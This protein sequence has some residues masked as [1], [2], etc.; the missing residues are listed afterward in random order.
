M[1]ITQIIQGV[2]NPSAGPT[3]CVG[4]LSEE[5]RKLGDDASILTLGDRPHEWPYHAPLHVHTGRLEHGTGVSLAM[6]E[7]IR[8]LARA[9][10]ILHGNSIWRVTNL[11]PL[12]VGDKAPARIVCSPHGTLS[13]WSMRRRSALKTPFWKLLQKPA[14]ERC[15]CYHVTAAHEYAD[16]RRMGLRRPVALIPYGVDI[17]A[18]PDR[19]GRRK[20]AVFLGRLDPVKG[21]DLLLPAWASVAGGFEDWELVIAGPL[22]GDY[23]R[24]IQTQ[25]ERGA[26]PRLTFTG[27]LLGADK[28]RLLGEASLFI[29]PSYSENFGI[30]VAEA[31]A[32]AVPV[33]TTDATPWRDVERK[34]CGW[35]IRP[36][37][38]QLEQA[39]CDAMDRGISG[40]YD[41]G[42]SG[43]RWIAADYAWDRLAAM[44]RETYEWLLHGAR[45]PAFVND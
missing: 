44:M 14:L 37:R 17:P 28:S 23:A 20:K 1:Q 21:L 9:P 10:G 11:F 3:Y 19:A 7:S 39:L 33:I 25:A 5:L 38:A 2:H 22:D 34:R 40:L 15:H 27:Q 45:R 32:H 30:V 24:S 6:M 26:I 18:Q 13:E 8:R 4:R 41:M 12:L 29:L 43:R 16:I 31:L 35:C 42:V 36:D